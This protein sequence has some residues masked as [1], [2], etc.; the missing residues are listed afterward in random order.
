MTT[1][2]EFWI[3]PLRYQ[4]ENGGTLEADFKNGQEFSGNT[5]SYFERNSS[6]F[7]LAFQG[8]LTALSPRLGDSPALNVPAPVTDVLVSVVHETTPSLLTYRVW[9]KFLKFAKHKDFPNAA[10]DHKAAGW[11][12]IKFKE[13]YTRHVKALIAVGNGEGSD[14]RLGLKT[15]FVALSNPYQTGFDNL[16]QVALYFEDHPRGN[17]QVEV[18][19]RA[20]DET[21]TISLHRTDSAGRVTIPV[22]N[23]H[24]Y[25][26][27]AVV[28]EPSEEASTE[29][30]ATVWQTFWAALT[31]NV[32]Q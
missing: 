5:L 22:T 14:Q 11:S 25:L 24:D 2:H 6:R 26:F 1:A 13:S 29:E 12:E 21:V 8:T 27:D 18:F 3:E 4:I 15:E 17:A 20:P 28:L 16:M 31:F 30:G 19:D 32:P 23:G 10:A 9:E 7:D